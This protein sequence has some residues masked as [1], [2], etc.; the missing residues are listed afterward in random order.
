MR[1]SRRHVLGAGAGGLSYLAMG[2][3]SALAQTK[4]D[5]YYPV[6]VG[7]PVA[8]LID[9]YVAKFKLANPDIEVAPIYA[10]NYNDTTTKALTAAK[11]GAPPAVAVLLATD[12]FTLI[13]E[14]VIEP[15]DGFV[16]SDEDK[17]WEAGF[18][19]AF[20][21]SAK[22]DGHL[23]SV[24]F[25]RSTAVL[26]YNKQAFKEAGLE[27]ARYP[28]TWDEMVS[29]AKA[30]TRKDASGQ[31]VRWGLGIPGNVGS[32]QWLFGALAAQNGARLMNEAGTETY[33]DDPKVVE[34]LQFWVD[35]SQKDNIH[36]PGIFEWGTAPADFLAGRVAMIWHTTGNLANIRKSA[37]FDVGVAPFPGHPSPASVL[38]GGNLYVFK[39]ASPEQKAAA[40]KLIKFLTSDE[41]LA[42][43]AVQTGYV[44]P[45]DGSWNSPAL[46]DY[47]GKVPQALV[48]LAQI[49]NSV[50]E[51]STYDNARTTKILN[52][53]LAAALTGS[54]AP[55]KALADAQAEIVT[56]LKPYR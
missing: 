9:G 2:T 56:I 23:W 19:P 48:A 32:A 46:K 28:T 41:V 39:N 49:P 17:A 40:F 22:V 27:P 35:L 44:A 29:A 55:Q 30:V 34:A 20:L 38:G 52:D 33:L 18:M 12:I 31:V 8:R 7:G 11:A 6:Q 3:T 36:P 50:P 47:V 4:L 15:I 14:D 16:T 45:R 21:K 5:F 53:A 42:D 25:Q 37:S 13:D 26:Y 1:L 54:K 51:F 10:G 43:W 24:P